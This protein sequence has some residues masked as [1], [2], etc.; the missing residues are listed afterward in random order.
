MRLVGTRTV[1]GNRDG[2]PVT[3]RTQ[4]GSHAWAL[5]NSSTV[6]GVERTSTSSCT[7]L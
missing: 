4:M 3:S 2:V 6:V 1:F 5:W 7:R